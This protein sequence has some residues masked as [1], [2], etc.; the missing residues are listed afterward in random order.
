M[1]GTKFQ[2][3]ENGS[4]FQYFILTF[5]ILCLVPATFYFWS[6][7][8][9]EEDIDHP[10]KK[11]GSK[12]DG[13]P[14]CGCGPCSDKAAYLKSQSPG[15]SF[16][17]VLIKLALTSAW[18]IL[19]YSGFCISQHD[20][21]QGVDINQFDRFKILGLIETATRSE[22]KRAYHKLSLIYHPDKV[23]L[24]VLLSVVSAHLVRHCRRQKKS[25][26]SRSNPNFSSS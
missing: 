18:I 8:D 21:T 11:T 7:D 1:A 16:K 26:R 6:S 25:H 15:L 3:D 14:P 9:D 4:T 20:A 13:C 24:K 22:I 12:K 17:N 10:K 5:L 23:C 19:A 2:Y